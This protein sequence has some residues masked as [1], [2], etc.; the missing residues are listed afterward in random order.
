MPITGLIANSE[1][2]PRT[3]IFRANN[4]HEA[5]NAANEFVTAESAA[6]PLSVFIDCMATGGGGGNVDVQ[7]VYGDVEDGALDTPYPFLDT[8]VLVGFEGTDQVSVA[9]SINAILED[10]PTLALYAWGTGTGAAAGKVFEVVAL[11]T[12]PAPPPPE[13]PT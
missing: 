12:I 8:V 4:V 2:R 7:L 11:C 5:V 6:N 1:L 13:E 3:A 9:G 10:S